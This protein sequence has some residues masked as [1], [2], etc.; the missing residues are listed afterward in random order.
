M[1]PTHPIAG[2]FHIGLLCVSVASDAL[3]S[4]RPTGGFPCTTL[5]TVLA[6]AMNSAFGV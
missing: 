6:G 4:R 3:A 2:H 5:D 1:H